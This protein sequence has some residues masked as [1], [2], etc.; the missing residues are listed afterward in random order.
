MGKVDKMVR[1]VDRKDGDMGRA[2]RVERM[3]GD[4]R[5][6]QTEE[7]VMVDKMMWT[8]QI[9]EGRGRGRR[10]RRRSRAV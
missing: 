7:D 6:G 5:G 1:M 3:D 4:G 9:E 10:R 2:E 8:R